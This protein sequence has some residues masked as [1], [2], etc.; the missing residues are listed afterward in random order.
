M[1]PHPR[2][3]SGGAMYLFTKERKLKETLDDT[4]RFA[5]IGLEYKNNKNIIGI[6]RNKIIELI[7]I[8]HEESPVELIFQEPNS[9][10]T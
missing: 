8:F 7:D 4:F 2:G 5:G 10:K 3:M 1:A 6:S 9:L